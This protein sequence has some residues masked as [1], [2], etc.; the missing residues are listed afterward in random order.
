MKSYDTIVVGAGPAGSVT[1]YRLARAGASVLLL[2]RARFPRDKP[3]GGGLTYRAIRELPVSVEPVVEDVVDRFEFGFRYG[4]RFDRRGAATIILM[5]QRKRLDSLLAD[6]AAEAGAE[7]RDGVKVTSVGADGRVTVDG[8]TLAANVVVGADGVNGVTARSLGLETG[9]RFGVALEGNVSYRYAR[10]ARYRGRAVLE[11]GVIPGGYGWVFAKGDHLNVGVGGWESQA[12]RL[13][14]HLRRL[15]A[16]HEIPEARVEALRGYRLP[17]RRPQDPVVRG[18]A[19]LI[20][21]AAGLVDPLSGDGLYEAFVSSRLAADAALDVL[22]GQTETLAPYAHA[23]TGALASQAA[24]SWSAKRALDRFPRLVYGFA[25][26]PPVWRF[27]DALLR[28]ELRSPSEAKGAARAPLRVVK[29]L[30][31]AR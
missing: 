21:D 8:Q 9:Y 10:E 11:L 18:R 29:A 5:T 16:E 27:A 30:G 2:D 6:Q 23:L 3:C 17:L 22:S 20:G 31:A 19:L 24:A 15:C 7:F 25:R 26:L 14:D 4:S 12:P 28:G 1:A 13:R